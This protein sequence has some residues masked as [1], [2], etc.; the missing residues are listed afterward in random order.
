MGDSLC[1]LVGMIWSAPQQTRFEGQKSK[2]LRHVQC[3][4]QNKTVLELPP[5]P[6]SQSQSPPHTSLCIVFS[7]SSSDMNSTANWYSCRRLPSASLMLFLHA[8]LFIVL[9]TGTS[10]FV[11]RVPI[12]SGMVHRRD[13]G[14]WGPMV[15]KHG[16]LNVTSFEKLN[17]VVKERYQVSPYSIYRPHRW[18]IG[19]RLRRWRRP[20]CCMQWGAHFCADIECR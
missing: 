10:A 12:K 11:L 2:Q 3:N 20:Q 4:F 13:Y 14:Y 7:V 19:L 6:R 8:L 18:P 15:R 9:G 1:N 5:N 16:F 17:L